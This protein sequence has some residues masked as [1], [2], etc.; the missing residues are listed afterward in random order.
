MRNCP[1]VDTY[2]SKYDSRGLTK[3][4][5]SS[6]SS[7]VEPCLKRKDLIVKLNHYERKIRKLEEAIKKSGINSPIYDDMN[8]SE[9]NDVTS[10]E[11]GI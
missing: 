6:S 10:V 2:K 7:F 4:V 9:I 5:T 3:L 1:S 11:G 8:I